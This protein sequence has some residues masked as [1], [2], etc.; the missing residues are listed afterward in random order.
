MIGA[1]SVKKP[2][3]GPIIIDQKMNGQAMADTHVRKQP[4]PT[5]YKA[6]PKKKAKKQV[7]VKPDPEIIEIDDETQLI[8]DEDIQK[9]TDALVKSSERFDALMKYYD[10]MMPDKIDG[11]VNLAWLEAHVAPEKER[12]DLL[13]EYYMK[14]FPW[15]IDGQVDLA[16]L[17]KHVAPVM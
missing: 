17:E 16:F 6:P 14:H 1:P 2:E 9:A 10:T 11:P 3:E 7:Q 15:H 8:S 13:M 4:H 5:K 12:F